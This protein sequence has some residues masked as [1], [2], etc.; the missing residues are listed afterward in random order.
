MLREILT[1]SGRPGL[2]KL[3]ARGTNCLIAETLD[4]AKKR[5]PIQSTDKVVSLG[6]ISIF[7]DEGE[8]RLREVFL[9][10]SEKYEGKQVEMDTR[11]AESAEL[12]AFFAAVIPDYDR[13]RV[14][15]SHIRKIVS[16]YNILVAN[17]ISDFKE[18]QAASESAEG[19]AE[20]QAVEVKA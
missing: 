8:I 17:G 1:I 16:W 5:F 6:D 3:V 13:D 14:Y 18:E 11:K 7:T 20:E 12:N 15:P 19:S 10:I 4:E 9:K 2:S